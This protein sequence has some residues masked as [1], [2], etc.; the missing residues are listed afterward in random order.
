MAERLQEQAGRSVQ[1]DIA[2]TLVGVIG[3]DRITP[4][5]ISDLVKPLN[6]AMWGL[7]PTL[8]GR[9]LNAD[10]EMLVRESMAR[11]IGMIAWIATDGNLERTQALIAPSCNNLRQAGVDILSPQFL[12]ALPIIHR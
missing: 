10:H 7:N 1:F 5:T 11:F 2:T 6:L 8:T 9:P 3:K 12:L 4:D